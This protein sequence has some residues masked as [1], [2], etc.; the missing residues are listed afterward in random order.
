MNHRQVHSITIKYP[1]YTEYALPIAENIKR[2]DLPYSYTIDINFDD[3]ITYNFEH[4]SK[5]LFLIDQQ[6]ITKII[7]H[8][9]TKYHSKNDEI[10][11][12]E[13]Q[14]IDISN[15][16]FRLL[17]VSYSPENLM[18]EECVKELSK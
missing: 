16:E 4:L 5:E 17:S 3:G 7:Q 1:E 12:Q 15:K 2:I 18:Y 10:I 8:F 13:L 14:S 6:E 11:S 9:N